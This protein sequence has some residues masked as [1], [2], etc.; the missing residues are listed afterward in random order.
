VFGEGRGRIAQQAFAKGVVAAKPV[1][2]AVDLFGCGA[3]P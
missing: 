3:H 1:E 2:K